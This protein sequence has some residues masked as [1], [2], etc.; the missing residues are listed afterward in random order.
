MNKTKRKLLLFILL[1][2]L[3]IR[4]IYSLYVF[5]YKYSEWKNMNVEITVFSVDNVKEE[6][7]RY[8]GF[9]GRDKVI[10]TVKDVDNVYDFGDK[11]TVISSYYKNEPLGNPYEFDYKRYINSKD[12]ALRIDIVKI[13]N[14]EKKENVVA[15]IRKRINDTIDN[16]LGKYS[17]IIKSLMYGDESLLDEEF[18][19]KCR[20]I[21]IGHLL[22]VS[23]TH[24]FYLLFSFEKIIDD[25]GKLFNYFKLF[26]FIYFYIISLFKVS[27]LRVIVMYILN[28]FFKNLKYYTKI[29]ICM[30]II[31][32]INP[33]YVFNIGMIFSFLS[34]ISIRVFNPVILSFLKVKIG[35][36]SDYF[37]SNISMSLSCLVLIFPFQVYYFGLISPIAI[38]SSL[39][40]SFVLVWL[41]KFIFYSF[42]FILIPYISSIFLKIVYL[43]ANVFVFEINAINS[44]NIFNISVPKINVFIFILYYLS[45]VILM[46][47]SRIAIVYFWKIRKQAKIIMNSF[48]IL[49]VVFVCVW[50]VHIMYFESYVIYFNV[51]QGNMC[52]IH[53][54]KTNVIVDCGSTQKGLAG[55][56]ITTFLKAK[57]IHSIDLLVITH[58]HADHMNG[59]EDILSSGV[60]IQRVGF[61]KPYTKVYEC[62]RLKQILKDNNVGIIS[63]SQENNITIN[64]ITLLALTPPKDYYFMDV[65][66]LN[67]NSTVYLVTS[68]GKRMLFMGDSTKITE[69]YLEN[70]YL[71]LI[72]N[73]NYYQVSHHG[74][75]TSSLESFLK[76]FKMSYAIISCKESVYGHPDKEVVELLKKINTKIYVTEKTG[77]IIF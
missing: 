72:G 25:R 19:D 43:L 63:F 3:C 10:F 4:I 35:I 71:H 75:K 66:M 21:G 47:K 18:S 60:K 7:I 61:T 24:I 22:C 34:V 6:K 41:M 64:G 27:L 36:K 42:I 70:N 55:Q 53:N 56:V 73:I 8:I 12:I 13:L 14:I 29:W 23:G 69:K 28:M 67:A 1:V 32:I 2:I 44:I 33:Y 54:M 74:S 57:N 37:L 48:I 51:G 52:L 38:F 26:L 77:A 58:M 9:L 59:V 68:N 65:D 40:I 46:N 39:A 17:N 49:S 15:V 20:N 5:N 62:E 50:Y 11:I 45:L 30:Y 76:S 31:I 16:N